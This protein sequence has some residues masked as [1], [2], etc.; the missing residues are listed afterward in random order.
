MHGWQKNEMDEL[1]PGWRA[2]LDQSG[3]AMLT[4]QTVGVGCMDA[5]NL[6]A[7]TDSRVKMESASLDDKEPANR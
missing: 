1:K 5:I 3:L 7:A 2:R 6:T 4:V